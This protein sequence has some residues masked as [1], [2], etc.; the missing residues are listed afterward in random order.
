MHS[1]RQ[2]YRARRQE[3]YFFFS[4]QWQ[5][6]GCFDFCCTNYSLYFETVA[7][8]LFSTKVF[9]A[10]CLNDNPRGK[11]REQFCNQH[12]FYL[13]TDCPMHLAVGMGLTLWTG[14]M[15]FGSGISAAFSTGKSLSV[16]TRPL[17]C[18]KAATCDTG[19]FITSDMHCDGPTVK[20]F[21]FFLSHQITISFGYQQST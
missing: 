11:K 7:A 21:F 3:S 19:L 6:K 10:F 15:S 4:L 18:A 1:W 8:E 9:F 12:I 5:I 14:G 20:S 17:L 16:L 13:P 2:H